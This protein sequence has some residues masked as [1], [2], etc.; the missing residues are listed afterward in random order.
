VELWPLI[1]TE[2]R[3]EGHLQRQ[4]LQI[5]RMAR[6]ESKR[7]PADVD[8]TNIRGLKKEAQTKLGQIRPSTLGQAGRIS[9]ITPADLAILAVW[10]ER[11]ERQSE[12]SS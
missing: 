12:A 3:Y 11:Q 5:D 1:E 6:Q 9:G 7:I 10:M 8:Y 4:Q 2:Y